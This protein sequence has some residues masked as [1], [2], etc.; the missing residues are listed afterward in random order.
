VPTLAAALLVVAAAVVLFGVLRHRG[1]DK[2]FEL[3]LGI[4][5]ATSV[6]ELRKFASAGRPVYWMGPPKAGKLEVTR[7]AKGELYVRYLPPGVKLG[8]PSASYTTIGTYPSAN[9]FATLSRSGNAKGAMHANA[10][11][12]GLAVWQRSAATSVYLAYRG[13]DFLIEVYDP[14][15]RRALALALGRKIQPVS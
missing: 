11:R 2:P 13:T 6:G 4:P 9:A 14:S 12:H 5:T 7:N 10:A 3:K 1:R 15:P 8:D